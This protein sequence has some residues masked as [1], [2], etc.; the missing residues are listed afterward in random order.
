V[1]KLGDDHIESRVHLT[2]RLA[3]R[4]SEAA[5]ALG[6]SERTLRQI[7]PELPHVRLGG[8]IVI[9]VQALREWLRELTETQKGRIDGAVDEIIQSINASDND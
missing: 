3:L 5:K 4:P 2:E 9:P 1:S 6:V 7:L 8:R